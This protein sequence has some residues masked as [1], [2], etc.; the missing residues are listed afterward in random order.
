MRV[1]L[2][3][4]MTGEPVSELEYSAAS[5]SVGV[6]RADEVTVEIPGY[7][8]RSWYQFMVPRK[9]VMS[10][11]DEERRVLAAGV[12]GIPEGKSDTDGAHKISFP[13]T[14]VESLY[15][16]RHVLP[17]GYWPLVDATG[18]PIKA[19]NTTIT[20][21]DYGTIMK[22]LYMQA[23]NHEGGH[24]PAVFM[25]DRIGT[26]ERT[27]L[28]VDGK[29]V[30]DAVQEIAEVVGGVE[31]DW[32]PVIDESDRLTFH[33]ITGTDAEP[34]I[35]S[36]FW[37][38]WQS[39]GDDPDIRGLDF[40]I[41]PEF[42]AQTAIFMGGKDDDRV[43]A[44]R[45]TGS[46]LVAAGIPLCE[47]WDTSHTSVS[48]QSTLDGWAQ[49]RYEEGQAPIHYWTFD[50]RA[51]SSNGLRSGDW[52]TIDV[53]DHWGIPDGTYERRIVEVSGSAD[54]DWLGVVVAGEASW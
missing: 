5:W 45:R 28:A 12:L 54:S 44:S 15:E 11:I 38:A 48:R 50:V 20:G 17:V 3:E 36:S 14:G 29:P 24:I 47:V 43:M 31:W 34:E 22:R 27:Y 37:R 23:M 6:C 13:G 53:F 35:T 4:T 42:L 32:V 21:V 39:G 10:V 19:R 40:K 52:C 26:R 18:F 2:H 30:Q 25:P 41:S 7:T 51:E 16:R 9:F 33:L 8:G 1:L 46:A 49:A